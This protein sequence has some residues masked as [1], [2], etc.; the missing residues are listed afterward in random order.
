M[1]LAREWTFPSSSSSAVYTTKRHA[2]GSLSCNCRGWTFKRGSGPRECKHTR[3][4]ASQN[5]GASQVLADEFEP[6]RAKPAPKVV[7][8]VPCRVA[9]VPA[10]MLASAMV[11]PVKGKAFDAAYAGWVLEEKLDGHRATVR[12]TGSDVAA[13]SRPRA[14]TG[15]ANLKEVPDIMKAALL[16]M[17]PGVYDGELVVP[18]GNSWDVTAIGSRLVFVIF[19]LLEVDGDDLTALPYSERRAMLIDQLRKLPAGQKSVSTVESLP[20]SWKTVEAIWKRGGEGAILKRPNSTYRAGYRSPEWVKV[21]AQLA[22]TLTVIGFEAGKCGPY[23][24]LALRDDSGHETTCKTLGNA[25]LA[26]FAAAPQS[27]IGRRVVI[28]YQQK[29]PGGSYRHGIF[30]HFAGEGE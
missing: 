19:D 8:L 25:L 3:S 29:T 10:P 12:V 5:S 27:F 7:A 11:E 26:Q 18:G 30:D 6:A 9:S 22:A 24:K 28:S 2:D 17:S 15:V 23:S 13:W 16:H 1:S 21:K 20:V 14:G 4:I